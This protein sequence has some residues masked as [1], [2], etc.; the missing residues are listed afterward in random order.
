MCHNTL[1]TKH[2]LHIYKIFYLL[3][4]KSFDIHCIQSKF[5]V[6]ICGGCRKPISIKDKSSD[7]YEEGVSCQR[8]HD[9]LSNLQKSRFRMRQNQINLAKK[10]RKKHKFQKEY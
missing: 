10:A 7:K 3:L 4:K 6:S 8:C 2:P 1:G 5:L 9:T